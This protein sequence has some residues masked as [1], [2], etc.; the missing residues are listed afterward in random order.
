[1]EKRRKA[2]EVAVKKAYKAYEAAAKVHS[3]TMEKEQRAHSAM[4]KAFLAYHALKH[5]KSSIAGL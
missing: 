1:M 2:H 5:G 4:K 3:A